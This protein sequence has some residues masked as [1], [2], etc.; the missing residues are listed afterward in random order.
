MAGRNFRR[1]ETPGGSSALLPVLP[2]ASGPPG[3]SV[4]GQ[5]T[6]GWTEKPSLKFLML[7]SESQGPE[8]Q[9]VHSFKQ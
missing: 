5:V 2:S 1:R 6:V 8:K 9:L 7:S 3:P 4:G